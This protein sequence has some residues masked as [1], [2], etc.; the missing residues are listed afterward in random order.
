MRILDGSY[1]H[2][3]QYMT[4]HPERDFQKLFMK[5]FR[6]DLSRLIAHANSLLEDQHTTCAQL[7]EAT[8]KI[9]KLETMV[10]GFQADAALSKMVVDNLGLEKKALIA[11]LDSVKKANKLT[12]E[13]KPG[14]PRKTQTAGVSK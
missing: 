11:E 13:R 14:R 6:D 10:V 1:Q 5:R 12:P 2:V 4:S 8:N 7:V 3:I 9:G